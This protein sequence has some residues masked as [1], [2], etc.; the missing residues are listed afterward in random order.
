MEKTEDENGEE[1]EVEIALGR[2]IFR[3]RE[4]SRRSAPARQNILADVA[5]EYHTATASKACVFDENSAAFECESSIAVAT[6][7]KQL[8][9]ISKTF[10]LLGDCTDF[11][12]EALAN[13]RSASSS[14]SPSTPSTDIIVSSACKEIANHIHSVAAH[15]TSNVEKDALPVSWVRRVVLQALE[16]DI[17]A[18]GKLLIANDR[19]YTFHL[20]LLL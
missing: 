19:T 13:V 2:A 8:E 4:D 6:A 5:N 18:C 17:P 12:H 9:I 14:S 10:M 15:S 11:A 3:Y 20:T 16:T 7:L 1:R